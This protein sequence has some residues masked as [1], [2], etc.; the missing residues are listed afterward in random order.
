MSPEPPAGI[1]QVVTLYI[2]GLWRYPV[3]TLAGERL[4]MTT[5][6]SDGLPFDRIV[7]VHGPEGVRTSRKHYKLLGLRGTLGADG[8]P[9]IN[10]LPWDSP[11]ALALVKRAAGNDAWLE[12]YPGPER[13]DVLPLLVATDG[14]VNAFGRDIR[15]LR[16]NILIGGVEG[17][18]ETHWPGATLHVNDAIIRLDSLRGRC[19]MTTVDPDTL[20]RDPEVLRD[21][22]R[23]FGGRLALNAEVVRGGEIRV[24]DRVTLSSTDRR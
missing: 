5:L 19:P 16:P 4:P 24:G 8:R 7:Q 18:E 2:A 22:G 10:G 1:L 15:R 12:A 21:I 14:A 3:K 6:T 23:R 13:F 20:E 11:E 17:M 9:V